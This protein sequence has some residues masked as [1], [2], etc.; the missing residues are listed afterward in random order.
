M[1]AR[2]TL[3]GREKRP[4]GVSSVPRGGHNEVRKR[5][6]LQ[7]PEKSSKLQLGML[8]FQICSGLCLAD[9]RERR[10]RILSKNIR[11]IPANC[12][13]LVA[14]QRFGKVQQYAEG[15]MRKLQ[16]HMADDSLDELNMCQRFAHLVLLAGD[17]FDEFGKKLR[18]IPQILMRL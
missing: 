6:K 12:R 3:C 16:T 1:R 2:F 14:P 8:P 13:R 11:M 5:A 7:I 17:R 9:Q 15:G 10:W 18:R 4:G